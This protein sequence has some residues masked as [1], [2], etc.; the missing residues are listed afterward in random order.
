[1]FPGDLRF[2]DSLVEVLVVKGVDVAK[3]VHSLDGF[4]Y[5][6]VH[7]DSLLFSPYT[8]VVYASGF[9]KAEAV[10][11]G[12]FQNPLC[13]FLVV[14]SLENVLGSVMEV[15][16]PELLSPFFSLGEVL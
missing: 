1:V 5:M 16:N 2:G 10:Q 7:L 8:V 6:L 4:D 13:S 15:V 14:A 12:E 3:E 9:E 11:G